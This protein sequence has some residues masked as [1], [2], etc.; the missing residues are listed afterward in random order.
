MAAEAKRDD[1]R[2]IENI[3]ASKLQRVAE[4]EGILELERYNF[5]WIQA[6]SNYWSNEYGELKGVVQGDWELRVSAREKPLPYPG[7]Y[8][9]KLEALTKRIAGATLCSDWDAIK[10]DAIDLVGDEE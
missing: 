9:R 6:D 3:V 10:Q 8:V 2:P 1:H 5:Q 4:K 7:S